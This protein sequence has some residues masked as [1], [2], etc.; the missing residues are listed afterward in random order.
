[1]AFRYEAWSLKKNVPQ[2]EIDRNRD[3][4]RMSAMLLDVGKVA[5]SDDILHAG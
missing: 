1:M 2:Q 4:L 3:V 5:S